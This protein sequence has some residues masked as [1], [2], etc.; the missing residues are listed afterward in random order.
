ML[1]FNFFD[2]FQASGPSMIGCLPYLKS[3]PRGHPVFTHFCIS[4]NASC[5]FA[6]WS[7]NMHCFLCLLG[8]CL[9]FWAGFSLVLT[10]RWGAFLQKASLQPPFDPPPSTLRLWSSPSVTLGDYLCHIQCH[11]VLWSWLPILY[12]RSLGGQGS[13][14]VKYVMIYP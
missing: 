8:V 14:M 13:G 10:T 12:P 7:P 9:I 5:S 4:P 1:G 6:P 3:L 11:K 2:S